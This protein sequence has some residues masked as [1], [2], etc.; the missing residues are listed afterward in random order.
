MNNY[1]RSSMYDTLCICDTKA[2]VNFDNKTFL[3]F[4]STLTHFLVSIKKKSY[5]ELLLVALVFCWTNWC[6]FAWWFLS[7]NSTMS[8]ILP[9]RLMLTAISKRS[10]HWDVCIFEDIFNYPSPDLPRF[11]TVRDSS[12]GFIWQNRHIPIIHWH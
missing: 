6:H 3:Q 12:V 8:F 4:V 10:M 11:P 5:I 1:V 7:W 2:P 9:V